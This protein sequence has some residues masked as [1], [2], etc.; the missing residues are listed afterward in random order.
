MRKGGWGLIECF[1]SCVKLAAF[2]AFS[3]E[4][5]RD[6]RMIKI[7]DDEGLAHQRRQNKEGKFQMQLAAKG[8]AK[9][10]KKDKNCVKQRFKILEIASQNCHFLSKDRFYG[11]NLARVVPG[12][13]TLAI[14]RTS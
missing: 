11:S 6:F 13:G 1:F 4:E 14:M 3:E 9:K 5:R 8:F 12:A 7:R 10:K 2:T